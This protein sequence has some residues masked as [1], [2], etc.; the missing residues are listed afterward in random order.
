MVDATLKLSTGSQS[1]KT[2]AEIAVTK[3][4][5]LDDILDIA[6]PRSDDARVWLGSGAKGGPRDLQ[7]QPSRHSLDL[8]SFNPLVQLADF[9]EATTKTLPRKILCLLLAR[10]SKPVKYSPRRDYLPNPPGPL[11]LPRQPQGGRRVST[12]YRRHPK[13]GTPKQVSARVISPFHTFG[14]GK[15]A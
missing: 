8:H 10:A 3:D 9:L 14:E 1:S 12:V 7:T 15:G 5:D 4:P 2:A 13:D 11:P 6:E